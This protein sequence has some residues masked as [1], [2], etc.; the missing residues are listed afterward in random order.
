MQLLTRLVF[1]RGSADA[2]G[3]VAEVMGADLVHQVLYS[4]NQTLQYCVSGTSLT[5][6]GESCIVSLAKV[7]IGVQKGCFGT[8]LQFKMQVT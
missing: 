3:K 7:Y 5:T 6:L 8:G 2:A 1:E 4:P